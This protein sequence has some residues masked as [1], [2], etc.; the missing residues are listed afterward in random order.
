MQSLR[1]SNAANNSR[2]AA[3]PQGRAPQPKQ[4]PNTSARRASLLGSRA[5]LLP[6]SPTGTRGGPRRST[7]SLDPSGVPRPMAQSI[8]T[9]PME[10]RRANSFRARWVTLLFLNKIRSWRRI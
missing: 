8:S 7:E 4:S 3:G 2:Q 5:A 6:T 10:A 1:I 9:E